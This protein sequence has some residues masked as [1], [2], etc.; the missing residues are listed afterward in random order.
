MITVG[1]L[2]KPATFIKHA[3]MAYLRH[4]LHYI[5]I[6]GEKNFDKFDLTDPWWGCCYLKFDAKKIIKDIFKEKSDHVVFI[7]TGDGPDG[8]F[9]ETPRGKIDY[10]KIRKKHFDM[11]DQQFYSGKFP[12]IRVWGKAFGA[13]M[14]KE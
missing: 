9:F 12:G 14:D 4:G 11:I 7:K 3:R 2:T 5:L 10:S 13:G 6:D 1:R 8:K